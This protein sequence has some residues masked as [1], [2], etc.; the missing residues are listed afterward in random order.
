MRA[1]AGVCV[2]YAER[3]GHYFC[4]IYAGIQMSL[5]QRTQSTQLSERQTAVLRVIDQL[6]QERRGKMPTVREIAARAG[7]STSNPSGYTKPLIVKGYLEAV[8]P[9]KGRTLKLTKKADEWLKLYR[10]NDPV[11]PTQHECQTFLP[12][13]TP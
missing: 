4:V 1:S 5:L 7:I 6:R 3:A 11:D 9:R 10:I 12:L 8:T 2:I 13:D